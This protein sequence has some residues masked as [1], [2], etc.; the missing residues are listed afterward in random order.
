MLTTPQQPQRTQ[1]HPS[2]PAPPRPLGRVPFE[3]FSN[4][5]TIYGAPFVPDDRHHAWCPT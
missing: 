3:C 2:P 1:V 5:W 4:M